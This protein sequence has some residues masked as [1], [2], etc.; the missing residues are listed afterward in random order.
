[1][2]KTPITYY[3]G[4]QKLVKTIL[5]L[6]PNH[7]LYCEPFLGGG[8]IFFSKKISPLEVINDTNGEL[9]NF[10]KVVQS[11]YTSLEKEIQISLHSRDLHRKARVIYNNPDMFN[12]IKRAWAIWV[13]S[14][15]SFCS[16][17]DGSFGYDK[18]RNTVTKKIGN[19]KQSFTTE[20]AIRLQNACIESVDALY[21]IKSR[22]TTNSFFYCDPPYFNSDCAHYDGYSE[23]DFKELLNLLQNIAG[24]FL[25]S[26]YPSKI[27]EEYTKANRWHTKSI[28]M[29]LSAAGKARK[30]NSKKIEVLTANYPI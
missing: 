11:D 14:T 13:L 12:E 9:M 16:Q 25:L 2:L 19:K 23:N 6:I 15:Q 29:D 7:E 1:M 18:V 24:K 8:A 4:K 22:D 10:Y 30:P 26:S 17:L 5:P 20:Y 27:L 3:G 21:V 28:T